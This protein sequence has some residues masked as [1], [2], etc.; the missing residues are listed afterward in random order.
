MRKVVLVSVISGILLLSVVGYLYLKYDELFVIPK[1]RSYASKQ[2]K[3]PSSATYRNEIL[4]KTGWLCGELNSKNSY[5][6][7]VG[8]KRFFVSSPAEAYLEDVGFVGEGRSEFVEQQAI[9][10]A[11]DV[12]VEILKER[13]EL[14]ESLKLAQTALVTSG[15]DIDLLVRKRIFEK[16]WK[17]AC[18]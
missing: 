17:T 14:L 12:K 9:S 11:L 15:D 1:L 13:R 18:D 4:K 2:L 6:G 3:D 16:K 7:Y 10:E 8:F 5:G